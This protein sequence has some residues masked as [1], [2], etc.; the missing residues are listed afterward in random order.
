MKE[1]QPVKASAITAFMKNNSRKRR[2]IADKSKTAKDSTLMSK[3][4]QQAHNMLFRH[5]KKPRA[6]SFVEDIQNQ[7]QAAVEEEF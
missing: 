7:L 6:D 1:P 4:I 5:A 2:N 3:E